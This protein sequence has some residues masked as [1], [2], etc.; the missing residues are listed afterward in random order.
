MMLECSSMLSTTVK[1]L[2]RPSASLVS[3][4]SKSS[5][6]MSTPSSATRWEFMRHTNASIGLA[7]RTIMLL[8]GRL[9]AEWLPRTPE[10][11]FLR[12]P[13]GSSSWY[14]LSELL[15]L[16]SPFATGP[17]ASLHLLVVMYFSTVRS[18]LL[19]ALR[20]LLWRGLPGGGRG[21]PNAPS[22]EPP[23]PT[24]E[25]LYES[26]VGNTWGEPM[27]YPASL[28]LLAAVAWMSAS[29]NLL[30]LARS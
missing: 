14:I 20:C 9:T 16:P 13:S 7:F 30:S 18:L 5:A 28:C 4:G 10:L 21:R 22:S 11:E 25:A 15:P 3:N 23:T 26:S 12:P 19:F 2:F 1:H 17:V 27:K 24:R 6:S 29:L 8:R